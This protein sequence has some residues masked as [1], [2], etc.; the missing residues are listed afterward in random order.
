MTLV[1]IRSTL[2]RVLAGDLEGEALQ[3]ISAATVSTLPLPVRLA[4]D[5]IT[6]DVREH[7]TA[8]ADRILSKANGQAEPL[9]EI[10]IE[11]L[12]LV[13]KDLA[14]S[15]IIGADPMPAD[16]PDF[17]QFPLSDAGNAEALAK[18]YGQDLSYDHGQRRRLVFRGHYW[19][20]DRTGTWTR[21]AIQTA[22]SRF[23]SALDAP[24]KRKASVAKW[25]L[26]SED[27]PRVTAM[28][29]LAESLPSI[30]DTGD[31]WDAVPM[32]LG[33]PNGVIDLETCKLR[34]GRRED[35]I[36]KTTRVPYDPGASWSRWER[37]LLEIFDGNAELV[38]F[39]WRAVGYAITGLTRE[40]VIF[41][42]Y[43]TGANGKTT[44]LNGIR[45]PLGQY[46]HNAPFSTFEHDG[47]S[48][49]PADV[50]DL[51]GRRFITS[52]ETGE[53]SRLN[54]AR[55]KALTGGDPV[56][57][58]KLFGN[59]RTFTMVGKPFL[60]VNHRPR[61]TDDSHGF[62]RRVRLIPFL[63]QFGKD[64]DR[65]LDQILAE[66]APGILAWAVRGCGEYLR[67][68]L[69]PPAIVADAVED[70]R[71]ESDP[72]GD[73]LAARCTESPNYAT[74][75]SNLYHEYQDWAK[76][77]GLRE[78]DTLS[79]TAFG[80]RMGARFKKERTRSGAVY[81]GVGLSTVTGSGAL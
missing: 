1:D 80:R 27:R 65:N 75:G 47:R 8:D 81:H 66:E 71:R 9:R 16:V 30:A 25:A 18:L 60:S 32:L 51:E 56:T 49:I 5:A 31:G 19:E 15:P 59:F 26:R 13:A 48:S 17:E 76:A 10:F 28:L 58:R 62:W 50:A 46:A 57:A 73:F 72:L 35:K 21:L 74:P 14:I 7:G 78:R 34:D 69:D 42:L 55:L 67:R 44:F 70:Y 54:E 33:A 6:E 45:W 77:A 2:A 64:A 52:S 3:G 4:F 12:E 79:M 36:T 61:V 41:L 63:R 37:F 68:G 11:L 23:R 29:A 53:A 40:Q 39:V 24:E 38:D 43:G 22:R 20:E